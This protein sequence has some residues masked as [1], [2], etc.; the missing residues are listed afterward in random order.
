MTLYYNTYN[1]VLVNK[2]RKLE[3]VYL[4]FLML[5]GPKSIYTVTLWGLKSCSHNVNYY[6]LR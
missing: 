4:V 2:Y 3:C 6:I 1:T 5:W